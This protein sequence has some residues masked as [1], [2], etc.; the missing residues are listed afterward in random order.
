MSEIAGQGDVPVVTEHS[1]QQVHVTDQDLPQNNDTAEAFGVDQASFDKYYKEGNFDW[2]S[3]GKEQAFKH[4]QAARNNV[5]QESEH[6]DDYNDTDP[7]SA[8]QVVENAGLA[9]EDLG[10]KIADE[11][12][13]DEADYDALRAIGI[14]DQV[15]HDYIEAVQGQAQAIIDNVIDD[16]GGQEAIDSVYAGLYTNATEEQRNKIDVLLR[17]PDT[18]QAGIETAIR[19]SGVEYEVYDDYNDAAQPAPSR[20]NSAYTTTSAQGFNSF[21]EQ[22]TAQRDPRYNRDA[23]YTQEVINRIAASTYQMNPRSHSGGM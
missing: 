12:D 19:L 15:V 4:Q 11:G 22:M 1:T 14:P 5:A 21:E 7:D 17:D 2:A 23:A 10:A 3:Y 20:G 13:I 6:Y 8:Q 16:I 9:W 18:R